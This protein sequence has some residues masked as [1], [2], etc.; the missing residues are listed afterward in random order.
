[1]DEVTSAERNSEPR[2]PGP[3]AGQLVRAVVEYDGT[4][5]FGFQIQ[6]NAATIQGG[7][8]A[9]LQKIGGAPV[10]I[11][12]GGRTD[13]GVHAAGQVI[14]FRFPWAHPLDDLLRAMNAHLPPDIAVKA[15]AAAPEG[16]HARFS[17]TGRR[18]RYSLFG[19]RIRSPLLERYAWR[20]D[21]E[22]DMALLNAASDLLI[23]EKDFGAFGDAPSGDSTVRCIR[24]AAWRRH[25]PLLVWDVEANAFLRRMVRTLVGTMVSVATGQRSLEGMAQLLSSQDRSLVAPPAPATGLCFME[26]LY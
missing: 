11:V 15:I 14:S 7:L 3:D 6:A 20:V 16:F 2:E 10:R 13:A 12:G 19:S 23:G 18:Y 4:Q 17:A 21:A 8:E 24:S 5:Y 1:V 9:A 26:V 22:P 25:G